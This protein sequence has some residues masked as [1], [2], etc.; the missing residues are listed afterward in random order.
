MKRWCGARFRT[1][2][3]DLEH[4]CFLPPEHLDRR[5]HKCICPDAGMPHRYGPRYYDKKGHP[6]AFCAWAVLYESRKED[7]GGYYRVAQTTVGPWWISTVWLGMDHNFGFV[8]HDEE[9]PPIIF[10]TMIF[11]HGPEGGEPDHDRPMAR[12]STL[13]QARRGHANAVREYRRLVK[14]LPKGWG[15]K[16]L[17]EEA[18]GKGDL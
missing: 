10:E 17:L 18:N 9:R 11:W 12:Y 16:G 3:G 2:F 14:S 13:A 7:G 1:P 8:R 15:T 6:I 4:R 5:K